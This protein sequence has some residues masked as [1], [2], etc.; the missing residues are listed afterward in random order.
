MVC[1]PLSAPVDIVE[2]WPV[3]N[4]RN[5]FADLGTVSRDAANCRAHD[6]RSQVCLRSLGDGR[7]PAFTGL[8]HIDRDFESSPHHRKLHAARNRSV[9]LART[10][11]CSGS[12]RPRL[13]ATRPKIRQ[14]RPPC[15]ILRNSA[16]IF[17]LSHL[18][19]SFLRPALWEHF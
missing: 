17:F 12:E 4:H 3:E 6:C 14:D 7:Y 1:C 5:R 9:P 13:Y 16:N 10:Q 19:V 18:P 8:G 15:R 2:K 11:Q